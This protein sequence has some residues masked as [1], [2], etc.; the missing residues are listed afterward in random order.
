MVDLLSMMTGERQTDIHTSLQ[1]PADPGTPFFS[2]EI[3][4]PEFAAEVMPLLEAHFKELSFYTDIPLTPDFERYYRA[5][6]ANQLRIFTARLQG[7]IIGYAVFFILHHMHYAT[8]K[9][10]QQDI[11]YLAQDQRG[12][13]IGSQLFD[14]S[15]SQLK[16]EGVQVISQHVKAAHPVLGFMCEK[17]GFQL[18]DLV[19][20]K[21]LDTPKWPVPTHQTEIV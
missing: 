11:L 14:W 16:S 18:Q 3:L 1:S 20:T 9:Q 19:Y 12:N 8:S 7:K 2:R 6:A 17:R 13:G 4:T 10:A 5:E 15:E 21:R